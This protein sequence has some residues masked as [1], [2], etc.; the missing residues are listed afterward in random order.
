[1]LSAYVFIA[2]DASNASAKFLHPC[3]DIS[4]V[5]FTS[6]GSGTGASASTDGNVLLIWI[7]EMLYGTSCN[8]LTNVAS[9]LPEFSLPKPTLPPL[10]SVMLTNPADPVAVPVAWNIVAANAVPLV[11]WWSFLAPK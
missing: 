3:A 7:T 5:I 11:I 1:M 6:A 9:V 10:R 4:E 8:D 2:S